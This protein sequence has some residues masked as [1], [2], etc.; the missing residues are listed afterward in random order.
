[1][2]F[3]YSRYCRKCCFVALM[4]LAPLGV[5]SAA[6]AA[7]TFYTGANNGDWDTASNWSTGAVP[8]G[9]DDVFNTTA[10]TVSHTSLAADTVKSLS[11]TGTGG[12]ALSGN[13]SIAG[14]Q[15]NQGSLFSIAGPVTLNA[16]T[17]D[18]LSIKNSNG[19]KFSNGY[20]GANTLQ[21]V[22]LDGGLNVG[23]AGTTGADQS[24]MNIVGTFQH[25]AG[26]VF[27]LGHY[28]LINFSSDYT[29][30]NATLHSV[31]TH[32]D[33][34]NVYGT[35]GTTLTLG[36]NLTVSGTDLS[37]NTGGSLINNTTLL[38]S[39]GGYHSWYV[40]PTQHS[41]TNNGTIGAMNAS[42]QMIIYANSFTNTGTL[43]S[44]AKGYVFIS[45]QG[46]TPIAPTN[47]GIVNVGAGSTMILEHADLVQT[48]GSTVVDGTLTIRE[49]GAYPDPPTAPY[50]FAL[51]GGSLSGTG[52]ISGNVTNTGGTIRP[53]DSPGML[54]ISPVAPG[55]GG[56]YTQGAG[57]TFAEILGGTNAGQ[58][59]VL[60]VAGAAS[61][62]GSL[63]IE[64]FGGF[65][66]TVGQSFTFLD[67]GS[68]SGQFGGPGGLFYDGRG[69]SYTVNYGATSASLT[70]ASL[71]A[72]PEASSALGMGLL[73]TLGGLAIAVRKRRVQA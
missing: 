30:D 28:G 56:N 67:Y 45:A 27:N 72:V 70:V 22:S 29:L 16:G 43:E 52:T 50:A 60:N 65:T 47:N 3:L 11:F 1:M 31:A 73:L 68:Q 14:S 40:Q 53:G 51:Q 7:D 34:P 39:Q 33:S 49:P 24:A 10:N 55:A 44:L 61:L 63:S 37:I 58:F 32:F 12:L 21:D 38:S 13:G 15:L 35:N 41:L 18:N 57:G 2:N 64:L 17:L 5:L 69:D 66:P 71:A 23:S 59:S 42:S 62:A 36:P 6:Q 4:T 19:I 46:D 48:A 8:G 9:T 54:T 25:G 20:A 26:A